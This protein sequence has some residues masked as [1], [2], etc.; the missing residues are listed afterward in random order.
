[1]SSKNLLDKFEYLTGEDLGYKPN[2]FEKAKFE[3]SS[4]GMSLSKTFK[5]DE[6]KK[7]AKSKGDFSY[8]CNHTFFEFYKRTD[9]FKD[10]S[11]GSKYTITKNFH[12]RLTKF[13]NIKPT[14]SETQLK[15]ERIIKNVEEVYRKCYDAYKDEYDNG[16][17]LNGVKNKKVRYKQF[18]IVDKTDQE[19]KLNKETQNLLRRLK[20]DKTVLIKGDLVGI[21]TMSLVH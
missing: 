16:D 6:I 12:K 7:V 2:V 11:L 15:K 20:D 17:E 1:M 21:L 14:K 4:L 3:Y 19:S 10:M 18:K 9:E 13:Q 8:D 5:E